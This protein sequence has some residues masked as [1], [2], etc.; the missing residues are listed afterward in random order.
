M[1]A[2]VLGPQHVG[3]HDYKPH[4]VKDLMIERLA[5]ESQRG[6]RDDGFKVALAI[7]GG[8]YAGAVSAGMLV[9]LEQVGF[10]KTVDEIVGTSTGSLNGAS[11]AAGQAALGSINYTELLDTNFINP[12]R[13]LGGRKIVNFDR[14]MGDLIRDRRPID[15][16][17]LAS[18][19]AFGAVSVNLI[20]WKQSC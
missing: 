9:V 6:E 10:I 5:S 14:L 1:S 11:A 4:P 18:G 15:P 13:A 2:E 19:P 17:K 3:T 20:R 7:E 16:D 12:W 8:G